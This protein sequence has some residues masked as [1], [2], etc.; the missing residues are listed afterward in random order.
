[1]ILRGLG[2]A[3]AGLLTVAFLAVVVV[4]P[5][6]ADCDVPESGVAVDA[7]PIDFSDIRK[8]MA[9]NGLAIGGYYAAETFG[10]PH[11]RFQTGCHLRRGVG[12]SPQC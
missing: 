2:L 12:G 5:A 10:N 3:L 8:S 11:R 7:I 1:M 9:E 4:A 6:R